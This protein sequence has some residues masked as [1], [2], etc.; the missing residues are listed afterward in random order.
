MSDEQH[1]R[2][3]GRA[4]AVAAAR[5]LFSERGYEDVSIQDVLDLSQLSRG[6]LYHHFTNKA[7]L[8]EA[9]LHDVEAELLAGLATRAAEAS[10][11]REALRSGALGF[12]DQVMDPAV[13]AI[14]LVNAP[15]ALGW[16]RWREIDGHYAFGA[17]RAVLDGAITAGELALAPDLAESYAHILLA[18]LLEMGLLISRA[19]DRGAAHGR[20]TR[21]INRLLDDLWAP[22]PDG[23]REHQPADAPPAPRLGAR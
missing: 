3:T 20:A 12:L 5:R 15:I 10:T 16:P 11:Q 2:G 18:A 17:L 4:R 19:E 13:A 1:D 21:A 23:G 6:A 8:F 22:A 9:V 7:E 14:I